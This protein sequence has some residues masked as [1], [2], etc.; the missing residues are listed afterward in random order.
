MVACSDAEMV[1]NHLIGRDRKPDPVEAALA[2]Q[3]LIGLYPA[4]EVVDAQRYVAGMTALMAA[5]PLD[6]VRRV[7][8]P[9]TGLPSRLKYLPTLADVREALE[10]ERVRRDRIAANAR[11]V[12]DEAGRRKRAEDEAREYERNRPDAETRAR[13]AKEAIES[14][15]STNG[16]IG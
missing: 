7:T 3:N 14:F 2:A 11:F 10:V 1:L 8:N 12:I 15:V 6:F 16:E 4:R 9:V 5:Y 13:Q